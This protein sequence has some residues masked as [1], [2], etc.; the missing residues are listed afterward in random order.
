MK[1]LPIDQRPREK[2]PA[3]GAPALA[4]AELLA[5]LL[6]TCNEAQGV[7]ALAGAVI[8]KFNGFAGLLHAT[9]AELQSFKGPGPA[10]RAELLAVIEMGRR[11]LSEQMQAQPVFDSP[12]RVREYLSL[13]L[14]EQQHEIFAALFLDAQHRLRVVEDM[15][16]GTLTQ[17]SVYPPEVVKRALALNAGAVVFSHNHPSGVAEPPRADECLTQTLKTA[18]QPVDVRALD[19]LV[20]GQGHVVSMAE[21]GL[22]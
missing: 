8:Q 5:L 3:R 20:V 14:R 7:L 15:F 10:K 4:D 18:L 12:Q 9:P 13:H 16:R 22:L 19:H 1:D 6:R 11:A 17:T 2:L 21:R